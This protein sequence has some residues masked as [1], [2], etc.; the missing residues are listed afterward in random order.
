MPTI[1]KE[2]AQTKF[3]KEFAKSSRP[4]GELPKMPTRCT[5]LNLDKLSDLMVKYT[6]WREYTEDLLN[7]ALPEFTYAKERYEH[8]K[9]LLILSTKGATV[10]EK[11]YKAETDSRIYSLREFYIEKELFYNMLL[12]KLESYNNCLTIIS[13]EITLRGIKL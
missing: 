1:K 13:R 4:D 11:T 12:N 3:R 6:G 10:K 2:N 8:E 9:E 5:G 7:D